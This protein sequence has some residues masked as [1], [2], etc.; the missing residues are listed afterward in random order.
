MA[1]YAIIETG[2]KQYR[3]EQGTRLQVESLPFDK[4]GEVV[5]EKVLLVSTEKGVQ[6]GKPTVSGAKVVATVTAQDRGPKIIVFKKR[7]KKTYK[8]TIG[9]RQNYTELVIK[10]ISA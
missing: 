6:V 1:T 2:G 8:K 5:L 7:S 9:H 10:S 3:V 4:G